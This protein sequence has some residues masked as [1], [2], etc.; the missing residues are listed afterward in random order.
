MALFAGALASLAQIVAGSVDQDEGPASWKAL[1][2]FL[3]PAIM[4]NLSG[5]FISLMM[6]KVCTDFPLAAYQKAFQ[7]E[8]LP[9]G[10]RRTISG[11]LTRGEV[12]SLYWFVN[13]SFIII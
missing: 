8:A 6:V 2:V 10:I 13:G 5:A 1:R 9:V 12:S 7:V 4:L 3:Y 11:L